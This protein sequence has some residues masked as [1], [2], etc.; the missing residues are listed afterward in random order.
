MGLSS[1]LHEKVH[2]EKGGVASRN[3]DHYPILRMNETPTIEVVLVQ[4]MKNL[5]GVGEPGTPPAAPALANA[6]LRQPAGV[7]VP[8]P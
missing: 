4:G 5:G 7:Y 1:A 3:F 8:C 2:L 6:V